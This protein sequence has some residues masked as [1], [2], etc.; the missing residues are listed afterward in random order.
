VGRLSDDLDTQVNGARFDQLM[1]QTR[2]LLRSVTHLSDELNR[3]P[4]KLIFGDRRKG[5]TPQ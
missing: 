2:D 4:T 5:Y 1:G 3:E